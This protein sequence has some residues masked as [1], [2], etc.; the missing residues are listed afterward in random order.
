MIN[1]SFR[2]SI[3]PLTRATTGLGGGGGGGRGE[4]SV[5]RQC[6]PYAFC[7]CPCIAALGSASPPP[8]FPTSFRSSSCIERSVHMPKR[9]PRT[10]VLTSFYYGMA[11]KVICKQPGPSLPTARFTAHLS[12][13]VTSTSESRAAR[14]RFLKLARGAFVFS[15]VTVSFWTACLLEVRVCCPSKLGWFLGRAG[16]QT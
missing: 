2:L 13:F 4:H 12:S 11:D 8:S 7:A 10:T 1:Y 3:N 6:N 14:K 15:R 9:Y 16:V 5:R